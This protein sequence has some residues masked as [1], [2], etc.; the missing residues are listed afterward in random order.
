MNVY[1]YPLKE[2]SAVL[3]SLFKVPQAGADAEGTSDT[4]PILLPGVPLEDF[5]YLLDTAFPLPWYVDHDTYS[6]TAALLPEPEKAHAIHQEA[7][8]YVH[9][10][11]VYRDDVSS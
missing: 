1:R 3:A 6:E 11:R 8:H 9:D 7:T 2:S 10:Q 4:C 5:I